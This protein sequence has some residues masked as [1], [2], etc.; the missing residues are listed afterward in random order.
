ME[1]VEPAPDSKTGAKEIPLAKTAI[2]VLKGVPD[3]QREG[4]VIPGRFEGQRLS[5]LRHQWERIRSA[6]KLPN[7]R[8]H[9]LRHTFAS[10]GASQGLGLPMLG[11]LLGHTEPATT[12]R[13]A[14]LY[15]DPL[16]AAADQIADAVASAMVLE[17]ESEASGADAGNRGR[18]AG[19]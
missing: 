6:G 16:R 7:V 12:Q 3:A 1:V 9:D 8:L 10:I 13:Y 11:G 15:Q 5:G 4:W 2:D 17:T 18:S 19:Q 14:H